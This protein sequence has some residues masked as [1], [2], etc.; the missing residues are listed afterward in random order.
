MDNTNEI[1]LKELASL[2]RVGTSTI[3]YHCSVG[4]LPKPSRGDADSILSYFDKAEVAASLK[5]AD[6]DE[7]FL[8]ETEAAIFMG[9]SVPMIKQLV[10]NKYLPLK[11]Y[12]ISGF[13]GARNFFR[14]SDLEAYQADKSHKF[15]QIKG[16]YNPDKLDYMAE[17][18]SLSLAGGLLSQRESEVLQSFFIEGIDLEEIGQ[19]YNLTAERIRQILEKG[20]RR[21]S[22]NLYKLNEKEIQLSQLANRNV[23]LENKV[24]EL[25]EQLAKTSQGFQPET[26]NISQPDWHYLPISELMRDLSVR[27]RNCLRV[28]EIKT[29]GELAELKASQLLRYRNF[30]HKSLA[31]LEAVMA[32]R[33]IALAPE[34]D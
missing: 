19:K 14:Q 31:E 3:V 12:E 30:G 2:L 22:L 17:V 29:W 15:L 33:D 11:H 10:N 28:T 8:T 27:T 18:F 13:T 6:L 4:N 34:N 25:S 16:Y 23:I 24:K 1:S 9:S 32:E 7:P 20:K 5:V 21:L 26:V